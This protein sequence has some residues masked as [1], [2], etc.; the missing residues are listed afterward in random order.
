[1]LLCEEAGNDRQ[2]AAAAG[3]DLD[4]S[5]IRTLTNSRRDD[6][7]IVMRTGS[8]SEVASVLLH[9]AGVTIADVPHVK[10]D[11]QGVALASPQTMVMMTLA[12]C[13][14]Q[15][16]RGWYSP[17]IRSVRAPGGSAPS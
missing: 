1:L 10:R 16:S 13:S 6:R 5:V 12:R 14:V 8:T 2:L 3:T 15:A 4:I 11:A 7:L 9:D 17:A